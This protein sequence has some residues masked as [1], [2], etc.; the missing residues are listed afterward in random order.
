[1]YMWGILL[2]YIRRRL[3]SRLCFHVFWKAGRDICPAEKLNTAEHALIKD[4]DDHLSSHVIFYRFIQVIILLTK[5][6]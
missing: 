1:V 3:S 5:P 2:A 4:S 6:S